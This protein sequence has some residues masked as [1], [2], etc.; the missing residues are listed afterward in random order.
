MGTGG[1]RVPQRAGEGSPRPDAAMYWTAYALNKL[2]RRDEALT[3]IGNLR[4]QHPNSRWLN[5]AGALEVEVK[6]AAGARSRPTL[7]TTRTSS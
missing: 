6:Q 7:W 1:G 4:K 3:T 2:G 5:D